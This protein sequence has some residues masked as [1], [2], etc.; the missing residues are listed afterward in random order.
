MKSN[1]GELLLQEKLVT[2]EQL[3]NA[4]D[5]QKKNEVPIGSALIALGFVSEEEMA[6]ALSRQLGYP[7]VD[8]D[9]FEVYPDVINLIPVEIAQKYMMSFSRPER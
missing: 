9:Q 5:F 6:Q 4:L 7:Y 2:K 1:L 8:L 3:Q